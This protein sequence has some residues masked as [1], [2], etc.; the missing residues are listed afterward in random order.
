MLYDNF[1]TGSAYIIDKR[2]LT[3]RN[4]IELRSRLSTLDLRTQFEMPKAY[5][6]CNKSFVFSLF[7]VFVSEDEA[8]RM[9]DD[10]KESFEG[11]VMIPKIDPGILSAVLKRQLFFK[12]LYQ[13]E[14][15]SGKRY[16]LTA[17]PWDYQKKLIQD[18]Q[19]IFDHDIDKRIC[20]TL[21]PGS[22]KTYIASNLINHTNSKFL[23]LVYGGDLLTQNYKNVSAFLNQKGIVMIN[24]GSMIHDLDY[25]KINGLFMTQSMLREYVSEK[26]RDSGANYMGWQEFN[27]ILNKIGITMKIIDEFDRE[28]SLNYEIDTHA[29]F[30]YNLY[31]TGTAFKSLKPDDNIF[32]ACYRKAHMLGKDVKIP[33]NKELIFLHCKMTPAPN[34]YFNIMKTEETFKVMY[35][36]Y[37]GK[38]HHIL[39]F[40][41][42]KFYKPEKSLFKS[43]I[44]ENGSIVFFVGRIN[45]CELVKDSLVKF[46]NIDEDDIGIINSDAKYKNKFD[47]NK[48]KKFIITT[49]SSLGRGIDLR[50]LR[51]LI[52]LEFH[53]SRSEILQSINRVGRAG[54]DKGW[55]IMPVDHS[56]TKIVRSFEAKNREGIFENSFNKI[57]KLTM[58]ED[59]YKD[60]Y[61]GYRKDSEEE[62]VIRK[63]MKQKEK[64]KMKFSNI[65]KGYR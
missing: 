42:D 37:F 2:N 15:K 27:K 33:V 40:I 1:I 19:R 57:S 45:T 58:P 10:D 44:D 51:C 34:E 14:D 46:H 63:Y 4:Q 47:V 62:K 56:F 5:F 22:G 35:N 49:T 17:E 29:N 52:F 53:F 59:F 25:S 38:K 18:A 3:T 32:Q 28:T 48:N 12:E 30:K 7:G 13:M 65:I 55:V 6:E 23:F 50:N 16:N 26:K 36:N 60:Y 39:D 31:L 20:I 24:K 61:Y 41:M 43:L 11:Y 9:T 21:G 8:L 54:G 64:R